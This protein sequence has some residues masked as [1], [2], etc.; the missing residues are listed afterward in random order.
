MQH[1]TIETVIIPKNANCV[2]GVSH[3][4]I[5]NV[6]NQGKVYCKLQIKIITKIIFV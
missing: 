5:F 6:L 3:Y 4:I 2:M 1:A